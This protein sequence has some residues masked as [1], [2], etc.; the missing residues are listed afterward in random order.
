MSSPPRD[1]AQ[2]ADDAGAVRR[3][4]LLVDDEQGI[5]D[6]LREY[7]ADVYDVDAAVDASQA[8]ARI[9]V[10]RPDLVFLDIN[11]PGINGV[12]ALRLI[13]K[14][15]KTIPVIMVTANTDNAL[16]AEAIKGGAF[17]YIPKPFNL[18]Y[19]EHLIVAACSRWNTSHRP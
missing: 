1:T 16:A 19:L 2:R 6:I 13:K 3:R 12:E 10:Q 4:I 15:D 18:K 8:L 9:R 11:M 17:S 5:I 7:L 14:I